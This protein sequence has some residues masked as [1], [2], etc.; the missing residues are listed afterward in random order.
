MSRER[1]L[2]AEA[3]CQWLTIVQDLGK[4][5]SQREAAELLG[6]DPMTIVDMK[7]KGADRR[8]AY[9]CQAILHDLEPFGA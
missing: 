7:R 2:S 6:V 4:A 5:S 1:Y 3:F 9:A 8:T